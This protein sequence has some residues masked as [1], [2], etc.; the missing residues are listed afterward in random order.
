MPVSGFP[1]KRSVT[2]SSEKLRGKTGVTRKVI[3]V[4]PWRARGS[5][6]ASLIQTSFKVRSNGVQPLRDELRFDMFEA[7]FTHEGDRCT[8]EI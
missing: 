7:E 5:S 4:D 2:T 6:A 3:Y 1:L 8:L